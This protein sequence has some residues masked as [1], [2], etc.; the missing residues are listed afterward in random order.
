[1]NLHINRQSIRWQ[2]LFAVLMPMTILF[3]TVTTYSLVDRLSRVENDIQQDGAMLVDQLIYISEYALV[4]GNTGYLDKIVSGLTEKAEV[5]QILFM[6]SQGKEILVRKNGRALGQ[7][8]VLYQREVYLTDL[9]IDFMHDENS[10]GQ[11]VKLGSVAL[12]MNK[13]VYINRELRSVGLQLFVAVVSLAL[14]IFIGIRLANRLSNQLLSIRDAVNQLTEGNYQ[15]SIE[16]QGRGEIGKV[17]KDINLLAS[18]LASAASEIRGQ[19][20]EISR[21]KE[22][23][24]RN[25]AKKTEFIALF[26][27]EI[28]NPMAAIIGVLEIL[29]EEKSCLPPLHQQYL[30]SAL[31]ASNELIH[32]LEDI[33]D[34]SSLEYDE[35]K[36]VNK[37]ALLKNLIDQVEQLHRQLATEK[38]IFIEVVHRGDS[39]AMQTTV[40]LD[41]TRMMQILFNIVGNAIKYTE[42]GSVK[43]LCDWKVASAESG[44]VSIQVIDSGIGIPPNQ[45]EKIFEMFKQI[46]NVSTRQY[47]GAGLGLHISRK[48]AVMMGGNI[49]VESRAHVGSTFTIDMPLFFVDSTNFDAA[50]QEVVLHPQ[51]RV[52]VVEDDAM[53]RTV[54]SEILCLSGMEVTVAC[55]AMDALVKLEV[56]VYDFILLDLHMPSIDG[57]TFSEKL[58][59]LERQTSERKTSVIAI[60]ADALA[61]TKEKCMKA[62]MDGFIAKPYRK[63]DIL[64]VI[65]KINRAKAQLERICGKNNRSG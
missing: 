46:E 18:T 49:T 7:T 34:F 19:V 2:V 45:L 13:T 29:A 10:A 59:E 56:A 23:A 22:Q 9:E 51:T 30:E 61:S 24:D 40:L 28:R 5:H 38:G 21:A 17:A 53:N 60:T 6:D 57:I 4:S 15:T 54:L 37:P 16:V 20:A 64:R 36:L 58:R 55:S 27:H 11:A 26:S 65:T 43:L 25:N 32:I 39:A 31:S 44:S 50:E 48:L 47:G 52:L 3:I 41:V 35:L 14:T 12:W 62:G 8:L 33:V 1:M 42:R 63:L